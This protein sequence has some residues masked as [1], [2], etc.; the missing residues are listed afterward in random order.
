MRPRVAPLV[1]CLALATSG[2]LG[3][4]AG[5]P[6]TYEA[7]PAELPDRAL[8]EHGFK[9]VERTSFTEHRRADLPALGGR[10]VRLDNHVRIYVTSGPG[11]GTGAQSESTTGTDAGS[12]ATAR[13]GLIRAGTDERPPRGALIV[14]STP[15]SIFLG[16]ELNPVATVPIRELVD[17][18]GGRAG[19][20]RNV[21]HVDST[22]VTILGTRTTVET[23]ATTTVTAEGPLE[24]HAYAVR[25]R[26]GSDYV[27]AVA[28]VPRNLS[29]GEASVLGA[30]EAIEH[31]ASGD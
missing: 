12:G 18:V 22:R 16:Q 21:S 6:L 24:T 31:P 3:A 8:V 28:V 19:E 15:R 5:G 17:R 20:Q 14:R 10:D 25:M 9:T 1:L 13:S 23:Y 29:G 4:V 11:S 26:H 7:R 2:C 30:I 27:V